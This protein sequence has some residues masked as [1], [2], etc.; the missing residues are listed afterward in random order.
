MDCVLSEMSSTSLHV[1]IV[2][3]FARLKDW[4]TTLVSERD[5]TWV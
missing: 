2:K 4:N 1:I 3:E 5:E